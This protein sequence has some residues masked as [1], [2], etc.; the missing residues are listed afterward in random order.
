MGCIFAE[1]ILGHS[2]FC[3]SN[4]SEQVKEILSLISLP[5]IN[6]Y[7]EFR[8][9][10]DYKEEY[11]EYVNNDYLSYSQLRQVIDKNLLDDDGFDLLTKMLRKFSIRD[12]VCQYILIK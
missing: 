4:E 6:S 8:E 12:S 1:M 7:I 10:P 3:G 11:E 5:G 2:L 9:L